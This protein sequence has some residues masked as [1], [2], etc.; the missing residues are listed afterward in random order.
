VLLQLRVTCP[1]DRTD[2]V[3]ALFEADA[4][5]AHLALLPGASERPAGDLVLAD[6]AR[7]SADGL[8]SALRDLDVH[9]DGAIAQQHAALERP[10]VQG[11]P[12][13]GEPGRLLDFAEE[14]HPILPRC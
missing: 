9:R 7:E 6:V 14:A 13:L 10:L 5:T 1:P 12:I 2:A 4:G 11:R 8:V 3:R